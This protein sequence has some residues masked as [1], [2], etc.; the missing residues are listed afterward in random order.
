MEMSLGVRARRK[1]EET[2]GRWKT[3]PEVNDPLLGLGRASAAPRAHIVSAGARVL[4]DVRDILGD[5]GGQRAGLAA[6]DNDARVRPER[7][8]T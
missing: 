5:A 4:R 7:E 6:Q 8:V 1:E 2:S 3:E